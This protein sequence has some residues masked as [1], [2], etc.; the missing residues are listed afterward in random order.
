MDRLNGFFFGP[1]PIATI[2][3]FFGPHPLPFRVLSL[4][5]DTWGVLLVVGIALWVF[6]RRTFQA[7]LGIVV[8]GAAT[9][10]GLTRLFTTPR[11]GG[12]EIISYADLAIG[13]FPSGHVYQA[14]GPWG[15]LYAMGCVPI[16]VPAVIALLVGLGRF[17]LGAHYLGDVLGGIVFAIALVWLFRRAWPRA[18]DWLE[19]RSSIFY[20]TVSLVAIA[21]TAVAVTMTGVHPRRFEIYGILFG[22][23]IALP[24]ESRWVRYEAGG[25]VGR[26]DAWKILFG[27]AGLL[28]FLLWD[29]SQPAQALLLGTLTA[30]LATLWVVL[31]APWIFARAGLG[32]QPDASRRGRRTDDDRV[33]SS[34]GGSM[35]RILKRVGIGVA[36]VVGLLLLWGAVEP[37]V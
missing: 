8:V 32:E 27:I 28:V 6:G 15:L 33:H 4:L 21:T 22:A 9:K 2:Q 11:P 20:R 29:R 10:I 19:R 18:R 16:W 34:W 24:L 3:E 5:G 25:R 7:V 37:R 35:L 31:A 14:V 30:G 13:S 36:A 12:P 23:A 17:Y 1:E 26:A